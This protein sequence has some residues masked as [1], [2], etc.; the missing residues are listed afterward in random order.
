VEGLRDCW[1]GPADLLAWLPPVE[2]GASSEPVQIVYDEGRP[3][4]LWALGPQCDRWVLA[5]VPASLTVKVRVF[6]HPLG[7]YGALPLPRCRKRIAPIFLARWMLPCF[8]AG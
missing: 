5:D 6:N 1:S 8:V 3:D 4:F 7:E 2:A